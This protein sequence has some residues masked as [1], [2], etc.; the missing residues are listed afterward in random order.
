MNNKDLNKKEK[1]NND[2]DKSKVRLNW[3]PGHMEKTKKQNH[4]ML[5]FIG[6]FSIL[7]KFYKFFTLK[8]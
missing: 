5:L 4:K 8:S 7:Y 2:N 3:Y 1:K 6:I